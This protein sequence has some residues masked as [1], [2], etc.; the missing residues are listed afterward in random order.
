M[1]SINYKD[2]LTPNKGE[3]RLTR[4][5]ACIETLFG[6]LAPDEINLLERQYMK[7]ETLMFEIV[8]I[9]TKSC[10]L[11]DLFDDIQFKPVA[12]PPE[13][14]PLLRRHDVFL[15]TIAFESARWK[16]LYLSHSYRN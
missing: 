15:G 16:I 3:A 10:T 9:N 11:M 13:L 4:L 14:M 8:D 2:L 12:F 6:H 1:M 5:D 7:T